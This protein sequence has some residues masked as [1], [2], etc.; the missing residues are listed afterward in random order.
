MDAALADDP[1][2]RVLYEQDRADFVAARTALAK[3]VAEQDKEAARKIKQ[4][5]KP[6]VAA[7][8]VNRVARVQPGVVADLLEAGA[9]VRQAQE[10]A[11]EGDRG[12]L[13]TRVEER[14]V[15]VRQLT[16]EAVELAG[17][18]HRDEIDATFEAASIDAE[19]GEQVERGL[20]TT[21]VPRP[22]GFDVL[23]GMEFGAAPEPGPAASDEDDDGAARTDDN[24]AGAEAEAAASAAAEE[25]ERLER[26][27]GEAEEA[28]ETTQARLEQAERTLAEAEREAERARDD[29]QR[30]VEERDSLRAEL[31]PN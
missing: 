4:L 25:R 21:A 6:S 16:D 29:A 10:R 13:R 20:L 18:S 14:R 22:S 28:V 27:L 5:R 19:V 2:V 15:L 1:R 12:Q 30:A 3:E 11:L 26:L 24:E 8:A 23:A 9:A 17:D 31:A 7:W